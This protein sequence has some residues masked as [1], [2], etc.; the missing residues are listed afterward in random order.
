MSNFINQ[1]QVNEIL[2]LKTFQVNEYL[3]NIYV[4][5]NYACYNHNISNFQCEVGLNT[6]LT[7]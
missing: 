3:K 4:L 1:F 5:S 2:N 7:L 6:I